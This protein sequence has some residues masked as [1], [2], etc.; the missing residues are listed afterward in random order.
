MLAY[1]GVSKNLGPLV[2]RFLKLQAHVR[3]LKNASSQDEFLCQ[4]WS[5]KVKLCWRRNDFQKNVSAESNGI[6]AYV[7]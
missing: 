2:F 1:V 4:I 5:F 6:R 7:G 3:S